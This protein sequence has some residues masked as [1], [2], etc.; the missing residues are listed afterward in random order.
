MSVLPQP[1]PLNPQPQMDKIGNGGKRGKWVFGRVY[2][3]W[4]GHCKAMESD[5][6]K[7]KSDSKHIWGG[8]VSVVDIEDKEMATKIPTVNPKIVSNGFPTLFSFKADKP[9][10]TLEYYTGERTLSSMMAWLKGKAG[11][12]ATARPKFVRHN[13]RRRN[14]HRRTQRRHRRANIFRQQ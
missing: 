7:L 8:K 9:D 3:E 12:P 11:F 10:T 1:K 13:T 2:A 14:N 6:E 5:W 4:C